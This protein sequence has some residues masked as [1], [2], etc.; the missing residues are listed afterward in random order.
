MAT[1]G[2]KTIGGPRRYLTEQRFVR[3]VAI[4]PE[5][6]RRPGESAYRWKCICDCGNTV[7]MPCYR[8]T[9]G[10]SRSCGCGRFVDATGRRYG[11]LMAVRPT[12]DIELVHNIYSAAWV[13]RCDC[14]KEVT[15]P[16]RLVSCPK[17]ARS[18]GCI[19]VRNGHYNLS[20]I[21]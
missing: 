14:G 4:E 10:T 13:F 18:C 3:L 16:L 20:N 1:H 12:G 11:L 6:E 9:R 19:H 7:Y 5:F 15:A 8:L 21:L 2:A 17:G